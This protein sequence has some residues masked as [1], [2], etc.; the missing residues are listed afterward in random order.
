MFPSVCGDYFD[1]SLLADCQPHILSNHLSIYFIDQLAFQAW[2]LYPNII[3]REIAEEVQTSLD[4]LIWYQ[5][6]PN[7]VKETIEFVSGT[8]IKDEI[9]NYI[10][11]TLKLTQQGSQATIII[12]YKVE[13]SAEIPTGYVRIKNGSEFG[14]DLKTDE[15]ILNIRGGVI[16]LMRSN[17]AGFGV[18]YKC[19]EGLKHELET[20]LILTSQQLKSELLTGTVNDDGIDVSKSVA[21]NSETNITVMCPKRPNE[22]ICFDNIMHQNVQLTIN[23]VKYPDTEFESTIG[24]RFYQY[25]LIANE[26]DG[27]LKPTQEFEDSFTLSLNDLITGELYVNTISDGSSFGINFQLE[28]TNSKYVFDGI[29]SKGNT[30]TIK[31]KGHAMYKGV[32]KENLKFDLQMLMVK[33]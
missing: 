16:Q 11:I 14:I 13:T 26:L 19:L 22:I 4:A 31:F 1:F 17:I 6:N 5:V 25:Q 21:L 24:A 7:V 32:I 2:R 8:E 12:E 10:P 27:P 9:P 18:K 33:L 15:V 3:C 29:N 28:I 23:G 20:P 30:W